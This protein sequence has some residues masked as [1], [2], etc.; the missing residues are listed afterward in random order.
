M[1]IKVELM[2]HV[3]LIEGFKRGDELN[4]ADYGPAFALALPEDFTQ[5]HK[6]EADLEKRYP[7]D[8]CVQFG[9]RR[10]LRALEAFNQGDP[11]IALELTQAAAPYDLAVPGTAFFSGAFFG[12]LYP[13]MCVASLIPGW[14][15]T[16]R[17]RPS[18]EK[19]WI[20]R[21]SR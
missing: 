2:Q 5:A 13:V 18:F 3:L 16:V 21:G 20:I 11:V 10:T 15:V 7:E 8:T 19:S 14:A 17:Q 9:Y 1:H 12:A 6:I 4:N